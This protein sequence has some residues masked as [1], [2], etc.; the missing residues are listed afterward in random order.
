M[1]TARSSPLFW[2]RGF[3]LIETPWIETLRQRPSQKEHGPETEIPTEGAWDQA[4]RQE[5]TS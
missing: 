1:H 3:F 4:A 2:G 5:V